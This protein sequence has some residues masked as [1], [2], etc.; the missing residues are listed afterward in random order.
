MNYKNYLLFLAGLSLLAFLILRI[1][2]DIS[3]L[4]KVKHLEYVLL[5]MLIWLTIPI[6]KALRMKY[7]LL[8]VGE[9]HN[10][11]GDI[12]KIEF[13]NTFIYNTTLAKLRIPTKALFLNRSLKVNMQNSISVTTLEYAID[14][15]IF[16]TLG[17]VGMAFFFKGLDLP[18]SEIKYVLFVIL[19]FI[20][21]FFSLSYEL[22][23]SLQKMAE[24]TNNTIMKKIM[25]PL[26][27]TIKIIREGWVVAVLNKK[28]VYVL[29]VVLIH[30]AAVG[31]AYKSLFLSMEYSVP[32]LWIIVVAGSTFLIGGIVPIPAGLGV[33]EATAVLLY[34]SLGVP[35]EISIVVVLM[36]R[37][38]TLIP[39]VIGY[40]FAVPLGIRSIDRN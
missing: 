23:E 30:W 11:L 6:I 26:I 28:I 12:T 9:T 33:R 20:F 32:F 10:N 15:F 8:T 24:D 35:E 2:V 5:T 3:V 1:D 14:G 34:A 17:A 7:L 21:I 13:A 27:K 22:F 37:M 31:I 4:R 40:R 38:L 19:L 25:V 16:I 29:F 39:I 18:I 36:D